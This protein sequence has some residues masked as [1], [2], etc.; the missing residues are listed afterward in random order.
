MS[1]CTMPKIDWKVALGD[2]PPSVPLQPVVGPSCPS[3]GVPFGNHMGI[4]G[5]CRNLK[6][7]QASEQSETRWAD[8]YHRRVVELET[9]IRDCL[10]V[11]AHL[12]D[13]EDCTLI[14]LKRVMRPNTPVDGGGTL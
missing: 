5:M 1:S 2:K 9:A 8:D 4:V 11:N 6:D 3:C 7:A 13:G 12:A 10:K 14:G